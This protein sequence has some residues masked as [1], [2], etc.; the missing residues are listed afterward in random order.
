IW[1]MGDNQVVRFDPKNNSAETFPELKS[2]IGS[3]IFSEATK[4]RLNNGE[5]VIGYSNGVIYF[6]PEA[7]KPYKFKPYLAISGFSVNNKE[8]HQINK[9][10]P[11]NPDL[12]KEVR[13]QHDQNF[14]RIQFSALNYLKNE[15]IVYRYK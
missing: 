15:N 14:F 12:L 8:L 6:Q 9:E 7:I 3:E 10:T 13:L 4:C 5:I 2:I 11:R 1:L